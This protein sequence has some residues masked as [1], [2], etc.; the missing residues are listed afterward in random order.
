[1]KTCGHVVIEKAAVKGT[2]TALAVCGDIGLES[3]SGEEA[4]VTGALKGRIAE[5]FQRDFISGVSA[6]G[7]D[8]L[9]AAVLGYSMVPAGETPLF[10]PGCG[11]GSG[12]AGILAAGSSAYVY[13]TE[14]SGMS[15]AR[16]A[17]VF[18]RKRIVRCISSE[19]GGEDIIELFPGAA[20]IICPEDWLGEA[21]GRKAEDRRARDGSAEDSRSE[22]RKTLDDMIT[23]FDPSDIRDDDSL[24][25]HMSELAGEGFEGCA[26]ALIVK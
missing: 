9:Q 5:A 8:Y 16:I 22:D 2:E 24:D 13:V 14:G 15:I 17:D 25:R 23:L 4:P 19:G 21:D 3:G 20:L 1:M 7:E 18:G 6:Y 26:A 10:G 12:C 11:F